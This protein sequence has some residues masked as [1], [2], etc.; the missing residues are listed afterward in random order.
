MSLNNLNNQSIQIPSTVNA[1][2]IPHTQNNSIGVNPTPG[3]I[4]F[5]GFL[6]IVFIIFKKCE[7]HYSE[8]FEHKKEMDLLELRLKY[9]KNSRDI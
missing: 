6:I 8:Y 1:K 9:E 3:I 5:L 2:D 4:C 7:K